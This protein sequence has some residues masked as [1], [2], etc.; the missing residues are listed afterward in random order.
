MLNRLRC[1]IFGHRWST[2][3]K[4]NFGVQGFYWRKC[5]HCRDYQESSKYWRE[6]NK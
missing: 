2:W 5:K 6:L 4:E 3:H 1:L